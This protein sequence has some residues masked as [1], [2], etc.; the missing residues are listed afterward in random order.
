MHLQILEAVMAALA[1]RETMPP[2]LMVRDLVAAQLPGSV[3]ERRLTFHEIRFPGKSPSDQDRESLVAR[4]MW[5]KYPC[6]PCRKLARLDILWPTARGAVAIEMKARAAWNGD[7]YGYDY[8][9]D[10]HRLERLQSVSGCESPI[11][12]RYAVF[13]TSVADYWQ[14]AGSREP[15]AFRIH[16]GHET[17]AHFWVQYEQPSA[18]TRWISYPPFTLFHP[19]RFEWTSIGFERRVLITEVQPQPNAGH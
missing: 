12:A 11:V 15:K 10:L 18:I 7:T 2:E 16:D 6:D 13:V 9:K 19:Y 8:L 14:A 1:G 3:C 5:A 17:P 4:G